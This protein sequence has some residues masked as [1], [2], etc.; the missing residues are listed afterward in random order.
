MLD[1]AMLFDVLYDADDVLRLIKDRAWCGQEGL[2]RLPQYL[3][4]IGSILLFNSGE[5]RVCTY[6]RVFVQSTTRCKAMIHYLMHVTAVW[7]RI[8]IGSTLRWT[9]WRAWVVCVTDLPRKSS[10][11]WQQLPRRSWMDPH[12]Y[13]RVEREAHV[14]QPITNRWLLKNTRLQ[15]TWAK[16]QFI[17]SPDLGE[18]PTF[19]LPQNLPL[20]NLAD[21]RFAGTC[22]LFAFDLNS[23]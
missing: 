9:T 16:P 20:A 17:Y 22:T 21:I 14:I 8:P 3:P 18:V 7:H 6:L 4:S 2:G 1:A 13:V 23:E 10:N 19:D 11:N 15:P 12:W 5:V